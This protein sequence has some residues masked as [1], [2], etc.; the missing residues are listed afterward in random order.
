MQAGG[1]G[2]YP[3]IRKRYYL[4]FLLADMVNKKESF[5]LQLMHVLFLGYVNAVDIPRGAR[6]VLVKEV[7]PCASFLGR[8]NIIYNLL[9][10]YTSV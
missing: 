9:F 7:K 5:V 6:N 8:K 10:S 1:R 2:I 3:A 4:V